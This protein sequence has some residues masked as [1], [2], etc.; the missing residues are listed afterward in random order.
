MTT[1]SRQRNFKP[2]PRREGGRG[3]FY[4]RRL[5]CP[6]CA[7]S[8]RVISYKD[9]PMLRS[10]MSERA[11][12]EP[13]RKSGA[14]AKHQRALSRAIKMARHL[15][16]LPFSP[17]HDFPV[18]QQRFPYADRSHRFRGGQEA[19]RGERP[20]AALAP[21]AKTTEQEAPEAPTAEAAPNAE[22]RAEES[23]AVEREEAQQ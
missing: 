22:A 13:R 1:Q 3:R 15:A 12:I 14:C 4:P 21:A 20:Q 17:G 23:P 9:T 16:L 7:D 8:S 5:V 18:P 2:R 11:K 19:P 10:F 6:F